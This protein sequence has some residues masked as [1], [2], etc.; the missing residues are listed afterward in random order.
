MH[1]A[2][3]RARSTGERTLCDARCRPSNPS[4][5]YTAG[6]CASAD[7]TRELSGTVRRSPAALVNTK[8]LAW[9]TE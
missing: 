2:H 5:R 9:K 7:R 6:E 8:D 4:C 1:T 3:R